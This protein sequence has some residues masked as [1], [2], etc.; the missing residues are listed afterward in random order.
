MVNGR[1]NNM[2]I[3]DSQVEGFASFFRGRKDVWGDVHGECIKEPV[4][5]A[6]YRSHLEGK[7]SLGIYLITPGNMVSFSAID[8][9]LTDINVPLRLREALLEINIPGYLDLPPKKESSYNVSKTGQKGGTNG[10]E[11]LHSGTDY[12]QAEGSRD[13]HQSGYLHL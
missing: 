9:D 10:Q 8:V 11:E 5:L 7:G 12:Q 1:V 4:T 13:P 3:D 6:N 2:V